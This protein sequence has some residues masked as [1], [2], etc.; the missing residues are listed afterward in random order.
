MTPKTSVV[1]RAKM[2]ECIGFPRGFGPGPTP[3]FPRAE[4]QLGVLRCP[5]FLR[6]ARGY[7]RGAKGNSDGAHAHG[8]NSNGTEPGVMRNQTFSGMLEW[9]HKQGKG[10]GSFRWVYVKCTENTQVLRNGYCNCDVFL[11]FDLHIDCTQV[12]TLHTMMNL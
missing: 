2:H 1:R 6:R 4:Q 3:A 12:S 8:S 9:P 5:L 7:K 10:K 11:C